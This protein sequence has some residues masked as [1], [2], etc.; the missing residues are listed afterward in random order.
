M[1]LEI[2]STWNNSVLLWFSCRDMPLYSSSQAWSSE[3]S[4]G[5]H[6]RTVLRSVFIELGRTNHIILQPT[7]AKLFGGKYSLHSTLGAKRYFL[8][9]CSPQEYSISGPCLW[10]WQISCPYSGNGAVWIHSRHKGDCLLPR[11]YRAS[12]NLCVYAATGDYCSAKA[13]C[14]ADMTSF[15]FSL[16]K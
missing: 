5:L 14:C 13:G 1:I 7:Q 9:Y 8:A 10:C 4:P 12:L 16:V 2:L 3:L 6:A 15:L 11:R